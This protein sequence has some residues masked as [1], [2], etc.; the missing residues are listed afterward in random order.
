MKL[1]IRFLIFSFISIVV[2]WPL[3]EA[4]NFTPPKGKL[5]PASPGATGRA[6]TL[7]EEVL[8]RFLSQL[9]GKR[10]EERPERFVS[11]LQEYGVQVVAVEL[12]GVITPFESAGPKR[13]ERASGDKAIPAATDFK[14]IAEEMWH[15]KMPLFV[16]QNSDKY[17]TEKLA[18]RILKVNGIKFK[19]IVAMPLS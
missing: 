1:H 5:V 17:I 10:V 11:F 19:E 3:S 9:K 13:R 4:P 7:T 8:V 16:L 2:L 14:L 18:K 6:P 12:N 15:R